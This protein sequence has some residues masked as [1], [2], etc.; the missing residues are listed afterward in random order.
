MLRLCNPWCDMRTIVLDAVL[1]ICVPLSLRSAVCA[2]S[3]QPQ[4]GAPPHAA[5]PSSSSRMAM[6]WWCVQLPCNMSS[7]CVTCLHIA[8]AQ[9]MRFAKARPKCGRRCLHRG[10]SNFAK[11]R[12][13]CLCACVC[14]WVV[15]PAT[16]RR[17]KLVTVGGC[18]TVGTPQI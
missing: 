12:L 11:C 7:A 14:V 18:R 13:L 1:E 16:E 3:L 17:C 9:R 4:C 8:H 5:Q 2:D 15:R 10:N 6:T